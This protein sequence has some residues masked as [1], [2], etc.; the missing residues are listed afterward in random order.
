MLPL[1]ASAVHLFVERLGLITQGGENKARVG[2]SANEG[3][4]SNT[5]FV[6]TN[7]G[8]VLIDA[9]GTPGL[10]NAFKEI[11]A[12]AWAHRDSRYFFACS[13]P[14]VLTR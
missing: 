5:G 11:G 7:E 10:G 13:L 14:Y 1:T 8:V 3:F 6:V 12:D 9:L 2:V 4:N